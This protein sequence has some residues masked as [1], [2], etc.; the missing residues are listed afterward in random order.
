[1]WNLAQKEGV[2]RIVPRVGVLPHQHAELLTILRSEVVEALVQECKRS[3]FDGMVR[4]PLLCPVLVCR[5]GSIIPAALRLQATT[6]PIICSLIASA[7]NFHVP[8][9][10]IDGCATA[11]AGGLGVLVH[12]HNGHVAH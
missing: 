11:F 9:T 4:A 5:H 3:K 6:G 7:G 1:M 8:N 12:Q 2:P 10:Y